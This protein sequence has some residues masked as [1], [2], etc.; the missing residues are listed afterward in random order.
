MPKLHRFRKLLVARPNVV[1]PLR[2]VRL[3]LA[4]ISSACATVSCAIAPCLLV[5]QSA[6]A[7]KT[8]TMR[9]LNA[10]TK[11]PIVGVNVD[12]YAW[13][14]AKSNALTVE[15]TVFREVIK[16]DE[17]GKIALKLPEPLPLHL[18]FDAVFDLRGCSTRFFSPKQA[19]ASGVIGTF[20][21]SAEAS[22]GSRPR[23]QARSSL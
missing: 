9:F 5:G 15:E 2:A 11:K 3:R 23:N 8:I 21:P 12:V 22:N 19:V 1:G 7:P 10:K 4:L 18:A 13:N 14:V 17:E 6:A 20:K 16:T